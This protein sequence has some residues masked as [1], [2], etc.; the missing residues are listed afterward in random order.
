MVT[1][2]ET[3]LRM[4]NSARWLGHAMN[5]FEPR[6]KHAGKKRCESQHTRLLA[7]KR[8]KKEQSKTIIRP[9]LVTPF[10]DP[11]IK[12]G[13]PISY[14]PET[15]VFSGSQFRISSLSGRPSPEKWR[16]FSDEIPTRKWHPDWVFNMS[17]EATTVVTSR[18]QH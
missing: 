9:Y 2:Y 17:W 1:N 16:P 3:E 4:S 10:L 5:R 8:E 15:G 18:K 6:N 13:L 11:K 7:T 12:T 14:R